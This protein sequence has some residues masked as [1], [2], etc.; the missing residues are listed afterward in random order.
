MN[1][2]VLWKRLVRYRNSDGS[3]R[4]GEPQVANG[5]D[6]LA[7]ALDGKLDVEVLSGLDP[8]A[9]TPTG[10]KEVVKELLAPLVPSDVPFV[11]CIGLNY[12]TH[13]ISHYL[14]SLD[15]Y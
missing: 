10:Q 5:D 4:L 14:L 12:K 3:T 7:L 9:A 8:L 1:S 11:R 6:I 2:N 15:L 13:S